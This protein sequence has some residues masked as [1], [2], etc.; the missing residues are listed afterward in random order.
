MING[1]KEK[2]VVLR[3]PGHKY[4]TYE[5]TASAGL[6]LREVIARMEQ[7]LRASQ[8]LDH[9]RFI[10]AAAK[11]PSPSDEHDVDKLDSVRD[12]FENLVEQVRVGGVVSLRRPSAAV[13]AEAS[14][15]A[16]PTLP[17]DNANVLKELML[18]ATGT[19]VTTCFFHRP[20]DILRSDVVEISLIA[21]FL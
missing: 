21:D 17:Q 16:A 10:A 13:G 6:L 18:S 3:D 11:R 15:G 9:M 14:G 5:Q 1:K 2:G 19:G 7:M 8:H 4:R 12:Q 20:W